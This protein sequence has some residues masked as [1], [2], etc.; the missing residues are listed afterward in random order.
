MIR[1]KRDP[2][3]LAQFGKTYEWGRDKGS[4]NN[5][6]CTGQSEPNAAVRSRAHT[7]LT[8]RSRAHRMTAR[9]HLPSQCPLFFPLVGLTLRQIY[10]LYLEKKKKS[11][12]FWR[13]GVWYF[14]FWETTSFKIFLFLSN[15]LASYEITRKKY[16]YIGIWRHVFSSRFHHGYCDVWWYF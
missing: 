9:F 8:S 1:K 2:H 16:F 14:S 13:K 3:C 7:L 15:N 11:P 6:G 4:V 5:W 10:P 12:F